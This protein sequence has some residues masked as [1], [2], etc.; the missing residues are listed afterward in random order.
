MASNKGDDNKRGVY[1]AAV[2]GGG[3]TFVVSV[4]CVLSSDDENSDSSLTIINIGSTKLQILHTATIPPPSGNEEE[5]TPQQIINEACN[6]FK[7]HLPSSQGCY[8]ALGIAT[9]GPAGVNPT[10][11]E[12]YYGTILSGSPK[13]LWRGFDI[14]SPISES[15][16]LLSVVDSRVGFDTDVNAPAIA[17]FRHRCYYQLVEEEQQKDDH[18]NYNKPL[19][20]LAYITIGTGVGVGL[21]INSQPVHG[22]LHPEGG[23]ICVQP[24]P[25]DN[26]TGYSWGAKCPYNGK[27]T[28]EGIASSVALTERWIQME[29]EREMVKKLYRPSSSSSDNNTTTTGSSSHDDKSKKNKMNGDNAQTREVLTKLPDSHPIWLHASNAIANLCVSILL[30]TSCQKIVLGGGIMKRT[31]LYPMIRSRVHTLLNGYLDSVDELS[32]EEKLKDVIVTS[33]WE[34]VGSGLVGAFA[35]ALDKLDSCERGREDVGTNDDTRQKLK[36][37]ESERHYLFTSGVLA[38]IG[39]SFGCALMMS[40]LGRGSSRR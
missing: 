11:N 18:N 19:T 32:T 6:F 22:L 14:L 2:E 1:L 9:F 15:C 20:S 25:N 7:M 26:F 4:A 8:S 36:S 16:G 12:S 31:V 33:S 39:L 34:E 3:T 17:E 28:V 27:S 10:M 21:V 38:G 30:L 23:H 5:Y 13:K 37:E 40:L 35:L 24:L 29:Q